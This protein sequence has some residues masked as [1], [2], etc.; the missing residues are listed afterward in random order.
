MPPMAQQE[1]A[2]RLASYAQTTPHDVG[3][4]VIQNGLA[5]GD[6]S[7]IARA[8]PEVYRAAAGRWMQ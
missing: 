8:L 1:I 3:R 6:F 7:G 2:A 5:H 4:V